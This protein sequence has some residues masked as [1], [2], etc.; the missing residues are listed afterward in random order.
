MVVIDASYSAELV[1]AV[2]VGLVT[3]SVPWVIVPVSERYAIETNSLGAV[4]DI[5]F[6]LIVP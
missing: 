3:C 1:I 5:S 2:R 4:K 6:P